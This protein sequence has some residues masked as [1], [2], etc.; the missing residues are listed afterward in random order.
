MIG[1][2]TDGDNYVV[3]SSMSVDGPTEVSCN[4]RA[5]DVGSVCSEWLVPMETFQHQWRSRKDGPSTS[6]GV[7][8][9]I[10]KCSTREKLME[11]VLRKGFDQA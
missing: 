2:R 3:V 5:P 10:S 11:T 1:S 4:G 6:V 8:I 9:L 7:Y